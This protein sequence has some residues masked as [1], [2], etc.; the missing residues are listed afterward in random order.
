[1]IYLKK[2]YSQQIYRMLERTVIYFFSLNKRAEP[3]LLFITITVA[4]SQLSYN[5]FSN[6]CEKEWSRPYNYIFIDKSKKGYDCG[7]LRNNWDWRG[8]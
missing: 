2:I 8:L 7:K 5:D 3:S 6:I 1:M 4:G